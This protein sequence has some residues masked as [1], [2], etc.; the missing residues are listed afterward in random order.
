[1]PKRPTTILIVD[2]KHLIRDMYQQMFTDAGYVVDSAATGIEALEHVSHK[3]YDAILLDV[4]MPDMDGLTFLSQLAHNPNAS[5]QGPILLLTNLNS[6]D[7]A[8]IEQ[9]FADALTTETSPIRIAGH[10]VKSELDPHDVLKR[11]AALATTRA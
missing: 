9:D 6:D 4:M 5:L 7:V 1:M 11:V 10:I 3:Y 2:D 8:K